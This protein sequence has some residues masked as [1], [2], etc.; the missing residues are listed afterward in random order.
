M[1]KVL[2]VLLDEET[3]A[4]VRQIVEEDR[5][6]QSAAGQKLIDAGLEAL[7]K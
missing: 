6:S 2:Q 4:K 5:S 1:K 7:G 3:M